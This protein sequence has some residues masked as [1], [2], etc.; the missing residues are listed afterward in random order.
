[1]FVPTFVT[2]EVNKYK[3]SQR[4]ESGHILPQ[5]NQRLPLEA[6]PFTPK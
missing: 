5:I 4:G 3:G 6:K 2:G 1:M